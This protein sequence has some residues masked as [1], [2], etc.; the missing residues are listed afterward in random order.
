MVDDI[1]PS[2]TG[3]VGVVDPTITPL[4]E[5]KRLGL[6]PKSDPAAL[7]NLMARLKDVTRPD[8]LIN[9]QKV[10]VK[11]L[12]ESQP[13][14]LTTETGFPNQFSPEERKNLLF[15]SDVA[16]LTGGIAKTTYEITR[17]EGLS[18]YEA[19]TDDQAI[20]KEIALVADQNA[21]DEK[22]VIKNM[23]LITRNLSAFQSILVVHL[24]GQARNS[25][26][27]GLITPT[28]DA[29]RD[30][31]KAKDQEEEEKAI[32]AGVGAWLADQD[33]AEGGG[34][35][36]AEEGEEGKAED[37][38]ADIKEGEKGKTEDEDA[39]VGEEDVGAE[40]EKTAQAEDESPSKDEQAPTK[41]ERTTPSQSESSEEL[42]D[43]ADQILVAANQPLIQ[44]RAGQQPIADNKKTPSPTV[45]DDQESNVV[46][47]PPATPTPD[48]QHEIN[49][50]YQH[51]LFELFGTHGIYVNLLDDQPA[52]QAQLNELQRYIYQEIATD[53]GSYSDKEL[54]RFYISKQLRNDYLPTLYKKINLNGEFG[55]RLN[56]FYNSL[57]RHYEQA[58]GA[59]KKQQL[60][61][62]LQTVGAVS[63]ANT[64]VVS[65]KADAKQLFS[66]T[67]LS[68]INADNQIL[69]QSVT[70]TL[71][72]MLMVYGIAETTNLIMS[73][74]PEWLE[75]SFGL[76][77]GSLTASNAD[78]FRSLLSSYAQ[79][80]MSS[81]ARVSVLPEQGMAGMGGLPAQGA[82][83]TKITQEEYGHRLEPIVSTREVIKN[84]STDG[85]GD[86]V[87]EAIAPSAMHQKVQKSLAL[88]ESAWKVLTPEDQ[89]AI[90]LYCDI[91]VPP[92]IKVQF[93][94]DGK[95]SPTDSL[96]LVFNFLD[97]DQFDPDKTFLRK[98]LVPY[99]MR[100]KGK[101][102]KVGLSP[103]L[104]SEGREIFDYSSSEEYVEKVA[105]AK[106]ALAV[107]SVAQLE[108]DQQKRVV[109][110][111]GYKD[112]E[113]F[114]QAHNQVV[115]LEERTQADGS[116]MVVATVAYQVATEVPSA[117]QV[118]LVQDELMSAGPE[119]TDLGKLTDLAG[120]GT[121]G[122]DAGGSRTAGGFLANGLK[123]Y[124]TKKLAKKAT[125]KGA[126]AAATKLGMNAIPVLGT[127][128]S[129]TIAALQNKRIRETAAALATYGLAQ[130]VFALSTLG[131]MAGFFIGGALGF[132]AGG[133][134]GAFAGGLTGAHVGAQIIPW[135][136]GDN[137]GFSPRRPPSLGDM[138]S[139]EQPYSTSEPGMETLRSS[140]NA[141][142]GMSPL[143]VNIP[144][145]ETMNVNLPGGTS[146]LGAG[147]TAGSGSATGAG[148]TMAATEA[149]TAG[150]VAAAAKAGAGLGWG[151]SWLNGMSVA[152]L[153]PLI[154]TVGIM[155]LTTT[156][157]LVLVGAFIVPVPIREDPWKNPDPE[158]DDASR[159]VKITKTA[160]PSSI[161]NNT[162]TDIRYTVTIEPVGNYSIKITNSEDKFFGFGTNVPKI[163][164]GL[165]AFPQEPI[166]GS[167]TKEYTV[168]IGKGIVDT[169][170]VNTV[171]IWF[172]V[173]DA[174]GFLI[175]SAQSLSG[176]A[177]LRIGD[178]V[179][180]CWPTKGTIKQLPFGG[181]SHRQDAI[182][183]SLGMDLDAFDIAADVG[184]NIYTPFSGKLCRRDTGT[185]AA[186][187]SSY[188]MSLNLYF[189]IG[190]QDAVM[191]F[192]HLHRTDLDPTEC[193]DVNAGDII[194]VTGN[195]GSGSGP[196]LHLELRA[197]GILLK[198]IMIDGQV[199]IDRFNKKQNTWV[200]SC[201]GN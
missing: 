141:G 47:T 171:T 164:S 188:G 54:L 48:L 29:D 175:A 85:S 129:L 61:A 182:H 143:E 30:E 193:K 51:A 181:Y 100:V 77:R 155:T 113:E 33:T 58:E 71:D 74:R 174:N 98:Q 24:F 102:F 178:P 14:E 180:G 101:V 22:L 156:T 161:E 95:L 192:G 169:L 43:N 23:G 87:A 201:Y 46:P 103:L 105:E 96:P 166:D 148:S 108:P 21:I 83:Y 165:G 109:Q 57:G 177:Q 38:D 167:I 127:A 82:D 114:Y 69:L 200:Q 45:D 125:Q 97:Y 10:V 86:L 117:M 91:P 41:S 67:L 8:G 199:M 66:V 137:F 139:T 7:T 72:S 81:L 110:E 75:M 99:I 50:A 115:Q 92:L 78:R 132:L 20:L 2:P 186:L 184:T 31:D 28:S 126:L 131:G 19:G 64:E 153:S 36:D 27:P 158:E 197:K 40:E 133:P 88:L 93:E 56:N 159:F 39:Q 128:A 140:A 172:D 138:L 68:T 176:S 118:A 189:K 12:G 55:K 84:N 15:A 185:V 3:Q 150:K 73:I 16:S 145:P 162:P 107:S 37:E 65:R 112:V 11:L 80:R 90:Y 183:P 18:R 34:A 79:V 119:R 104:T 120:V 142:G 190:D 9:G 149:A 94:K 53:L 26:A 1:N 32:V 121:A 6:Y 154:G 163:Q 52:L 60:Q 134:A 89:L 147:E 123:N 157:I 196:H 179:M 130:T 62:S 5:V 122:Y 160:N 124:A 191:I 76:P 170:I 173:Y 4:D 187:K 63:S 13:R 168:N 25:G 146:G 35:E 136:W 152:T 49:W 59:A 135:Q 194:G 17:H 198:D 144:A 116:A 70:A 106:S 42:V 111:L 195:T 44:N 151:L